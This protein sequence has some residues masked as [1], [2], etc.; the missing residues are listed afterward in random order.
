MSV[1]L[2]PQRFD[3]ALLQNLGRWRNRLG[4][5]VVGQAEPRQSPIDP[6]L[7]G[8]EPPDGDT[9]FAASMPWL[10]ALRAEHAAW[11]E[12]VA[13]ARNW[14]LPRQ[15]PGRDEAL[16]LRQLRNE[17]LSGRSPKALEETGRSLV[18]AGQRLR[19][20][21]LDAMALRFERDRVLAP[22]CRMGEV[23]AGPP[24]H[25]LAGLA[26]TWLRRSEAFGP[27][28]MHWTDYLGVAMGRAAREGWPAHLNRRWLIDIFGSSGLLHGLQMEVSIPR[29]W[30][31][32]AFARALA[33]VG[34]GVLMASRPR[35]LPLGMHLHPIGVRQHRWRWLF[36]TLLLETSFGR[37]CLNLGAGRLALHRRHVAEA[38]AASLRI[39][40]LR[41]ILLDAM[42]SGRE[43]ARESFAELAPRVLGRGAEPS[44]LGILPAMRPLAGASFA[45]SLLGRGDG[46]AF[47]DRHD[48]DWFRNPKAAEQLR[49]LASQPRSESPFEGVVLD[50]CSQDLVAWLEGF[51]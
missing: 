5:G 11:A 21:A 13:L 25:E 40:A 43:Q 39:D 49:H 2:D 28:D 15:I 18:A 24:R 45:A 32:S 31:A 3:D 47:V 12:R 9:F 33:N 41:L 14:Q 46:A 8:F 10:Q 42:A 20:Q 37:V 17:L 36:A 51:V 6:R 29:P 27:G 26:R 1:F 22:D 50:R 30:G 35:G 4:S 23:L 34:Q 16:S 7:L 19:S 38:L 44:L 48:E